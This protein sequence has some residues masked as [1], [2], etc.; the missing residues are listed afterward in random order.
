MALEAT[1]T[2][3]PVPAADDGA[4]AQLYADFE[5]EHL[6]P[7]WT[8]TN[9]LMPLSPASRARSSGRIGRAPSSRNRTASWRS[10]H[11]APGNQCLSHAVL[12]TPRAPGRQNEP[13]GGLV[14]REYHVE[15][16]F[17]E[18]AIPFCM[19]VRCLSFRELA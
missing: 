5:A 6:A 11:S 10:I 16:G 3:D 12:P 8:Q 9:D 15:G 17:L 1:R 18:L 13:S 19:A 4:V 2:M 7:L 14:A